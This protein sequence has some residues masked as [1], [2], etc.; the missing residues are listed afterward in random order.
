MSSSDLYVHLEEAE[1]L[2]TQYAEWSVADS[3]AARNVISSLVFV[4]REL[5]GEHKIQSNGDCRI[6]AAAWPAQ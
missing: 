4:F 5:L 6:C 3:K 1:S 2:A